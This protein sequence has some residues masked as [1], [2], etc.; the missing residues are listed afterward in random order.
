MCREVQQFQLLKWKI[1]TMDEKFDQFLK[2]CFVKNIP[3]VRSD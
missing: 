3:I 2:I 1:R